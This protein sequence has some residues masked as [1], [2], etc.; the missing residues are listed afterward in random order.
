MRFPIQTP[1]PGV[2]ADAR[3]IRHRVS[4]FA[5]AA[6]LAATA[7]LAVPTAAH[8]DEQPAEAATA[9]V[10]GEA[11]EGAEA[12]AAAEAPVEQP[13]ADAAEVEAALAEDPAPADTAPAPAAEPEAEQRIADEAAPVAASGPEALAAPAGPAEAGADEPVNQ[14]PVA[15]DDHYVMVQDTTL[16]VDTPGFI[17]NDYDPD[18]TW[19]G[20]AMLA[21]SDGAWNIL[22][23]WDF[24]YTPPAGFIG[25][26]VYTYALED[27]FGVG[28]TA[29]ITIDVLP[30]GSDVNMPPIVE[31]EEYHYALDTPLYISAPGVLGNDSDG[32]GDTLAVSVK[33]QPGKGSVALSAD[34]SFLYTPLDF[35]GGDWWFEYRACDEV[36]CADGLVWLRQTAPGESPSGSSEPP[37]GPGPENLPPVA[38]PD[39]LAAV[40]GELA[41][42]DAPGVLAN[43]TDPEGQPL[44]LVSVTVPDHGVLYHWAADG[45]VQYVPNAGFTGTDQ[46][47]YTVSDGVHTSTSTVTFTVAAPVNHAPQAWEDEVT[48]AAGTT[49]TVGAPG[50]LGN[51][52]DQDGDALAVGMYTVAQHGTIDVAEDGG[53]TYA[54]D[55]GFVGTE[56]ISYAVSDG[57]ESSNTTLSIHVVAAGGPMAPSALGDH[58]TAMSGALLDVPAPGVLGNDLAPSGPV[59]VVGHEPAQHGT[60]VIDPDGSL[61]YTSDPGYTGVDTVRYT[62]SDGESSADALLSITVLGTPEECDGEDAPEPFVIAIA[63]PAD[64]EPTEP[65]D[66]PGEPG[67]SE[68][69]E[70]EA[71]LPE[72]PEPG[73][74]AE[75][76]AP[77]ADSEPAAVTDATALAATG[78]DAGL[79]A[80]LAALLAALGI[81]LRLRR[82]AAEH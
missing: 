25:T 78:T 52:S 73:R 82:R 77:L 19:L 63:V 36:L 74:P 39:A 22:G 51:D 48:T 20:L 40:A 13:V 34:G 32:D 72:S 2:E 31:D 62:I 9:A 15:V 65:C 79:V 7:V 30:A 27:D 80:T 17:A 33:T 81:A 16:H 1:A 50:V 75:E 56:V 54:P 45:E 70:P 3:S 60:I 12:P 29:T 23:N 11:P 71:G 69:G 61:R 44:S 49:L 41:I 64:P 59:A 47:E 42:L 76:H 43:D 38:E 37:A 10:A 14:L 4:A 24:E 26:R 67:G 68:P 8:A 18:G 55:A 28:N 57:V 58:Y 46:I 5:V 21:P 53:F 6:A 66:E 35:H